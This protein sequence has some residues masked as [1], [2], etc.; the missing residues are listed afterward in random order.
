MK[1][2]T[3]LLAGA[4]CLLLAG[5]A[6]AKDV[7]VGLSWNAIDNEIVVKWQEYLQSEGKRQGEPAGIT[8]KWVINVANADPARQA[9][10]IEDLINQGVNLIMARAEDASAIG[11][12]IR[13]A[14]QAGIPFITFDRQ[15]ATTK[16][17]AHVGGDSYDQGKTT[18]EAFLALLKEKGV[19][20]KCIELQGSLTDIN[21]VNRSKAWHE[22]T[23]KSGVITTL[24]SVPTEW[25][26]DKFR[27]G[28]VNA[29]RAHPDANCMFL[30]SD[31]AWPAVQSALEGAGK[32]AKTG[33][34]KHVWI[35]SQDIFPEAVKAME[36]GYID[37]GT[38]YD[39]Y[40][41]AKEAIRV[42]ILIA[43]GEKVDCP[44]NICL[45]KGRL[46]T[47]QNIGTMEN[48]WSRP[49]K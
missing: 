20:G 4:A 14:K 42:A 5:V 35:A 3:S 15:S 47:Q 44:D 25:N 11:A 29:L 37:L 39:A 38:T 8:F 48:L 33:D 30:A 27:S 23:D 45:A 36:E 24:E 21:A 18:A 49:T 40:A 43:K 2:L 17:T 34:P 31:F 41:H 9:A 1:R 12:S 13:A 22:I 6:H 19:Q 28:T 46:A 32:L 16:P 7:T 26:P 10:N